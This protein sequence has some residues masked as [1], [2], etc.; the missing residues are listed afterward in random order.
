MHLVIVH[1]VR[2]PALGPSISCL[3]H[4]EQLLPG[5]LIS[6]RRR[7]LLLLLITASKIIRAQVHIVV[8]VVVID[9]W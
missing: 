7:N 4:E 8:I 1:K 5:R 2:L 3:P 9:R 6:R